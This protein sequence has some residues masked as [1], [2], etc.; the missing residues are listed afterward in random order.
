M[1]GVLRNFVNAVVSQKI[2][3]FSTVHEDSMKHSPETHMRFSERGAIWPNTS[4]HC[5]TRIKCGFTMKM[6]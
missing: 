1:N 6:L 5:A 3:L 2:S 4:I